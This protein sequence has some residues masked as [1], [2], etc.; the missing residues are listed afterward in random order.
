VGIPHRVKVRNALCYTG[1]YCKRHAKD[2]RADWRFQIADL[3]LCLQQDASEL[4]AGDGEEY[5]TTLVFGEPIRYPEQPIDS[6][7][8]EE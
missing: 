3:A 8:T 2:A 7:G 4:A 6:A 1:E 5:V